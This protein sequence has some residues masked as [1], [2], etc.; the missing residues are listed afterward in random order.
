MAVTI[1]PKKDILECLGV[2]TGMTKVFHSLGGKVET[3]INKICITVP[4]QTT[5]ALK[6]PTGALGLIYNQQLAPHSKENLKGEVEFAIKKMIGDHADPNPES[7]VN[8]G[9]TFTP[10]T[11]EYPKYPDLADCPIPPKETKVLP[12]STPSAGYEFCSDEEMTTLTPVALA[13]ASRLYQPIKGTTLGTRYFLIASAPEANIAA[14]YK[15]NQLSL[16]I[17]GSILSDKSLLHENGFNLSVGYASLHLE[18]TDTMI[19]KR[20]VGAVLFGL[21]LQYNTPTP[22]VMKL[23][24]KGA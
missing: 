8:L 16:R 1:T 19:L 10:P 6:V 23:I 15:G 20:A 17:E 2:N 3:G 9:V 13:T 24:G 14:R 18:C 5:H 4:G 7:A 12:K 11:V 21:N 22:D